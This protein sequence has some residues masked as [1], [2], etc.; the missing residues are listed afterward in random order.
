MRHCNLFRSTFPTALCPV[1][2]TLTT[3]DSPSTVLWNWR[4]LQLTTIPS[5]LAWHPMSLVHAVLQSYLLQRAFETKPHGRAGS[6]GRGSRILPIGQLAAT[7]YFTSSSRPV[8]SPAVS[9]PRISHPIVR[10]SI[11]RH[12]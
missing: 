11:G 2:S 3:R 8:Y 7:R 12:K 1:R 5:L 9:T 4:L 6:I 10:L